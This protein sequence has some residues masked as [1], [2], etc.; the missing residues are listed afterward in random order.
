M[1]F[2]RIIGQDK[3]KD[4]LSV[5]LK[6]NRIPHA[7]L[8]HGPD[9]VGKEAMAIE[10][11]KA[12]MCQ[13]DEASYCDKCSDCQRIQQITHPDFFYIF[14][15][16]LKATDKDNQ[17]IIKSIVNDPYL[18][19][20]LWANAA[21]SINKIRELKKV[22]SMS[23]FENK[24]R[25]VII[26]EAE[27]MSIEA[28]NSL[29]KILEE[30]PDRMTIILVS[31][32]HSLLLPTIISRCQSIK[33]SPLKWD[34]IETSLMTKQGLDADKAKLISKLCFGNY[35]RALELLDEELSQ[36]RQYI[37]TILR[38]VIRGNVDRIVFVEELIRENDKKVLKEYLE[39]LLVWFRDIL[40][41]LNSK[42]H[43]LIINIDQLE[44][45]EKF[46]N[47]FENLDIEK[48]VSEI[49]DSIVMINRN[50]YIKLILINLF[51]FLYNNLRRKNG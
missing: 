48:I 49:E 7:L 13:Q 11:A 38:T 15:A 16:I 41:F 18:R 32:N 22:S 33:F 9:G 3:I 34:E 45:I 8:F 23:S 26:V 10:L 29:L 51:Y 47:S 31:S 43:D 50:V 1:A 42:D 25:V 21:I 20:R 35:R 46:A 40:I 28:T 24:G 4:I 5:S 2:E 6:N 44:I 30:P 17:A 39:L 14:P 27:M 19:E 37:L 12:I 36:R